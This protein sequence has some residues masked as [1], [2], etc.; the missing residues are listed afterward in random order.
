MIMVMSKPLGGQRSGKGW[1]FD[2][3]KCVLFVWATKFEACLDHHQ[4]L[5]GGLESVGGKR[6]NIWPTD[7]CL[8]VE[9]VLP[10]M[11]SSSRAS[12][13]HSLQE[14]VYRDNQG[15]KQHGVGEHFWKTWLAAGAD[16]DDV[17]Q[18]MY[19]VGRRDRARRTKRRVTRPLMRRR[20]VGN[21]PVTMTMKKEPPDIEGTGAGVGSLSIKE[22]RPACSVSPCSEGEKEE[23]TEENCVTDSSSLAA[24]THD[25]RGRP[26][27]CRSPPSS[28]MGCFGLSLLGRIFGPD[29]RLAYSWDVL[30][31]VHTASQWTGSEFLTGLSAPDSDALCRTL[32]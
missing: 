13:C 17:L 9:I 10:C 12:D 16:W 5:H 29:W 31:P 20:R 7:R 2:A 32:A 21:A 22:E 28:S 27:A 24:A 23:A 15:D 6:L 8:G 1:L 26:L 30:S 14:V 25:K 11:A 19:R 4:K 18:E 3:S